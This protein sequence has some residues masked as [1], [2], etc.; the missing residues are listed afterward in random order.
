MRY[1]QP[2]RSAVCAYTPSSVIFPDKLDQEKLSRLLKLRYNNAIADADL[3][4]RRG[5]MI[6]AGFQQ[7]L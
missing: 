6:F 2:A 4:S 5:F 1:G 3:G 7:Y